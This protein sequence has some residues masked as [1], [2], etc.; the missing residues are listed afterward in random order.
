MLLSM[1]SSDHTMTIKCT[2]TIQDVLK[3]HVAF[4]TQ[5]HARIQEFLSGGPGPT[6]RKQP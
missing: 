6:A 2:E 3:L 5:P 1:S 4:N